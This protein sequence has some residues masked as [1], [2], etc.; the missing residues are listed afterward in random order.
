VGV[1]QKSLHIIPASVVTGDLDEF[2][3]GLSCLGAT[4]REAGECLLGI[5]KR[6]GQQLAQQ[7]RTG[8]NYGSIGNYLV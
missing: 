3:T 7:V 2:T 5:N 4:I 8:S 6:V 1:V